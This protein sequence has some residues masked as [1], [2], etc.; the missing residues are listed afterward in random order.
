MEADENDRIHLFAACAAFLSTTIRIDIADWMY[1]PIEKHTQSNVVDQAM[2]LEETDVKQL[3]RTLLQRIHQLCVDGLFIQ[4]YH[5]AI[6]SLSLLSLIK[7]KYDDSSGDINETALLNSSY[8]E[9]ITLVG[10][11]FSNFYSQDEL[12]PLR[13]THRPSRA[14]KTTALDAISDICRIQ[15]DTLSTIKLIPTLERYMKHCWAI[16]LPAGEVLQDTNKCG[17]I[18]HSLHSL[19]VLYSVSQT[20]VRQALLSLDHAEANDV[21]RRMNASLLFLCTHVS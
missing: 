7:W 11:S 14:I 18:R 16:L 9:Y 20:A 13:W 4:S 21:M 8:T 3:C 10:L 2:I 5:S 6:L 15:G 17:I 1:P 12:L 19:L